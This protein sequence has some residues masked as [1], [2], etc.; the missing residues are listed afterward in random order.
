MVLNVEKMLNDVG[1]TDETTK[2]NGEKKEK[3]DII[4]TSKIIDEK[5]KIIVEQIYDEE[6]GCRFCVYNCVDGSIK[7]TKSYTF[8]DVEYFPIIAEEIKKKAILLPSSAEEYFEDKILD[9]EIIGFAKKWLDVPN[10]VMKFGLWNTKM[11]WVFDLFQTLNYLRVLGD[12]GT[13]KTRY[14]DVW[15]HLH[16]KP[17]FTSGNTTPAPLFR[18][19][20]KWRGTIVMDEAD[21]RQ[22]DE[23]DQIIKVLNLGFERGKF[24]MRCD[25]NDAS[26]VDL[27]EPF[28]PKIIATRRSFTDK[29]TESRCITHVTSATANKDIPVNINNVFRA[30]AL[31]LRNKLL[32]WRFKN[33]FDIKEKMKNGVEFDFGDIEPRVK[34]IVQSYVYLFSNDDEGMVGFKKYIQSYQ[35]ELIGERQSSFDGGI[36]EAIFKIME[37]GLFDLTAKDIIRKGG[38]LSI[39]GK[40]EMTPRALSSRLKSLGFM[41]G[42]PTR[43]GDHIERFI[44]I[45]PEHIK[46]LFKRYGFK[47]MFEIKQSESQA[48]L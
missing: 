30:E 26:K 40:R 45:N 43:R 12:T 5:E 27:F 1:Y 20:N 10:E 41:K 4:E 13:G 32:M 2:T 33:Y 22:S 47:I 21:L 28:C 8:N 14:M 37:G 29:A 6:K 25:Q 46:G 42:I 24:I 35:K 7:Y 11:S 18:L 3:K 16:Y 31:E 36:V 23:S 17:L 19:I 15:G 34:Q 39:D 44:P 38:F 48:N 9:D